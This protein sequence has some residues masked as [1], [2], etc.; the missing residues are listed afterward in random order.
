M[1][2]FV[3]CVKWWDFF[4]ALAT[5]RTVIDP[6]VVI[7]T[8]PQKEKSVIQQITP[9][10]KAMLKNTKDSCNYG[11]WTRMLSVVFYTV[12]INIIVVSERKR[13]D[14]TTGNRK[15]QQTMKNPTELSESWQLIDCDGCGCFL[16]ST[17]IWSMTLSFNMTPHLHH[18]HLYHHVMSYVICFPD[19]WTT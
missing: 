3:N 9:R 17:A 14:L 15:Q 10:G 19:L 5:G 12:R 11:N 16:S 8:S 13:M 6:R 2:Y 4:C 1:T 18:H 7:W